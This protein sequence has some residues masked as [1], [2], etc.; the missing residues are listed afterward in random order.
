MNKITAMNSIMYAN[1]FASNQRFKNT[2]QFVFVINGNRWEMFNKW[3]DE[4]L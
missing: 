3:I 1:T 4:A 2:N